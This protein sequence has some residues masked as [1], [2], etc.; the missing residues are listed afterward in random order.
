MCVCV[1]VYVCVYVCVC[2]DWAGILFSTP[3]QDALLTL[4]PEL[5]HNALWK[6]ETV[7][8]AS[9]SSQHST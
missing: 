1:C 9:E 6:R 3:A 5:H 2:G 7:L 8:K 4:L